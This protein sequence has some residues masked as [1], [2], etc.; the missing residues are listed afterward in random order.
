MIPMSLTKEGSSIQI[1]RMLIND[2]LG[3]RLMEIG[4]SKGNIIDVIKNDT[5]GLIIGI[6]GSRLALDK[7]LAN[8]IFV[9]EI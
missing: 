2:S 5:T 6:S 7:T 4:I 8:K 9:K 1:E 3:K